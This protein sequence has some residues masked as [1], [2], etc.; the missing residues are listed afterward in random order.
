MAGFELARLWKPVPQVEVAAGSVEIQRN[1]LLQR[2]HREDLSLLEH[3]LG[4]AKYTS[5][6]ASMDKDKSVTYHYSWFGGRRVWYFVRQGTAYLFATPPGG[7][8]GSDVF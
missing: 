7:D 8:D 4:Y 2:V 1:G 6:A 5:T 3:S